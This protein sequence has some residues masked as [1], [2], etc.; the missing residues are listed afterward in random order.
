[1]ADEP[2]RKQTELKTLVELSTLINSSLGIQAVLDNAMACVE[3]FMNA[4]ASAIFELDANRGE[5]FFR[6]ARGDAAQKVKEVRLKMGEGIAGWVAHTGK[7]LIISDAHKDARFFPL[8]DDKTGFET[9]SI[10]CVPMMYKGRLAGVLEVLNK[11]DGGHFDENDLEVLMVLGNQIAIAMENARLYTRLNEKFVLATEELKFAQEKL[12]QSE[13]LAAL[14]NLSQGVAH[15]VRNPVMIIGGFARRLQ[16]QFA[17]NSQIR[18]TT[19]IIL[20]QT[21]RLERMVVDIEAF[22]KL[23]QPVP[24]PLKIDEVLEAALR[25]ISDSIQS[26]EIEVIKSFPHEVPPMNGD[27]GLLKLASRNLLLNAVEAMPV[28]GILELSFSPQADGL[29][30]SIRDSGVGIPPEDLPNIF[31]P[32]FTSKTQG[33]GL[34]LTTVHRIISDHSGEIKVSS[35]PGEGTEV[36]IRL[37]Y[38]LKV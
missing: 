19:E 12:I 22:S 3:M 38:R 6:I 30:L 27:A 14:G 11:K 36:T 24:K 10:L 2:P 34:G 37:P 13:R 31:D 20:T 29:V 26:R 28:G 33:S 32:F 18:H 21:E 23:G 17:D 16:A 7:P 4:E 15:E 25:D 35:A 9:R 8:V 1:M 5:L